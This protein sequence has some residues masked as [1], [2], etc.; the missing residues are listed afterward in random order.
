M[1][2]RT[3]T[4]TLEAQREVKELRLLFDVSQ[5]LD[6]SLDVRHA[7]VPVLD[8]IAAHTGMQRATL[9]LLNRETG[10][11][12]IEAA[13][14]LSLAEQRRGR[15]KLGEGV[16]GTVIVSGKPAIVPRVSQEPLF[17]DR[18]LARRKLRK[19]DISFVSV[20]VRVGK[21][22]IGALS[23]DRVYAE[24]ASLE[25]DVRLLSIVASMLAQAVRLRQAAEEERQRLLAENTRLQET[26]VDRFRPTNMV[27][28]S[29]PM[30]A[31][32]D[33]VAQVSK[34]DATVLLRGESGVGK[35]LFAHAIHYNSNR[36]TRPFVKVNC[37]ALPQSV[38]ESE[39]F[40]HE[41]GAFTGAIGQRKGRFEMAHGG[42]IFLDEIGDFSPATQISLL[43]ILQ[44]KEF[45]R[46]GGCETIKTDV[47]VIA[48]TNQNLESL[49]TQDRFREDL[50]YRLN[51][52]PIHVPHLRER[53][54]DIL[55]LADHFVEKYG[56]LN[57][58]NVRR[59]ST[60]AI[61]MLMH[62][63]WPGN[64]RERENCMERA[65]WLSSDEVIHGHHLPPSLQTAEA[66]GTVPSTTLDETLSN[67]EKEL[68]LDALK[69]ARG[70][71]SKA[72]RA[73]G[74][75]ERM[76]GLRVR[77]YHLDARRFRTKM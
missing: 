50:Y 61:D 43:R 28:N 55:L 1:S 17:L 32:Y 35:E 60:P 72:A 4:Q 8:T 38:L 40:G 20:P 22:T 11:L 5:I 70:N 62:Y 66:S 75:T 77:K 7:V 52:F 9:T 46:V 57:G 2:L 41:K 64:V 39:L 10:E 19:H 30:Q 53:K 45:E 74:L 56:R 65:V 21:Q 48:A 13:S 42:T 15:Y 49:I 47:R 29:K 37:A 69:T 67:L 51:V 31:V 23:A 24:G 58:K 73:L 71:M 3:A 63:H 59:I 18:T 26:L 6:Q 16:V 76:M 27:G 34:S 68:I 36:A 14:G 25:D 54:A 44:E 12:N 33:L